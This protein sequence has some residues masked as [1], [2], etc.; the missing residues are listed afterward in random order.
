MNRI[1]AAA[2]YD[3]KSQDN[4]TEDKSTNSR[5]YKASCFFNDKQGYNTHNRHQIID[6]RE[7]EKEK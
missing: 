2:Y 4:V 6:Y 5:D 3:N 1:N 7:C